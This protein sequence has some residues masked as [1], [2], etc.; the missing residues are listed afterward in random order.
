MAKFRTLSDASGK[1]II[2]LPGHH[3]PRAERLGSLFNLSILA[4]AALRTDGTGHHWNA[5]DSRAQE[6]RPGRFDA[7]CPSQ[8]ARQ[9]GT[10]TSLAFPPLMT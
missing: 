6:C 3:S 8:P 5:P 4:P 10:P 2:A 9:F 1:Q 7:I